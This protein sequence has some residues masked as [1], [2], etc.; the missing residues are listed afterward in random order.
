MQ[1]GWSS[2]R[3]QPGH[4]SSV[5]RLCPVDIA[6]IYISR[7]VSWLLPHGITARMQRVTQKAS[8]RKRTSVSQD[9]Y[10]VMSL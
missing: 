8:Y 6:L 2:V 9:H 7:F 4:Y 1:S 10:I 3:E 5:I